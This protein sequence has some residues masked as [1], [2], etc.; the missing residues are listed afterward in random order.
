MAALPE[1]DFVVI[2]S[3]Q[4]ARLVLFSSGEELATVGNGFAHL[5]AF[6]QS[7]TM[8]SHIRVAAS[9]SG[10]RKARSTAKEQ[11]WETALWR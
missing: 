8:H 11:M 6:N 9:R 10:I 4:M 3:S 7:G 2:G 5:A 1:K